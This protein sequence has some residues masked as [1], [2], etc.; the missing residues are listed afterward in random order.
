M[1][2]RKQLVPGAGRHH[3]D[4][5]N[6]HD[7]QAGANRQPVRV[8][9]A[10]GVQDAEIGRDVDIVSVRIEG[11]TRDRLVAETL[12]QI[13]PRRLAG[14]RVKPH[15]EDV[16]RRR[17]RGHR[18]GVVAG[19]RDERVVW[20]LRVKRDAA[21]EARRRVRRVDARVGDG[22]RIAR[23]SIGADEDATA[24]C[25]GPQRA[26][27]ARR[28]SDRHDIVPS[29]ISRAARALICAEE[30]AGQV[31]SVIQV[32]HWEGITGVDIAAAQRNPVAAL[33]GKVAGELVAV[34]V[35]VGL[36]A[37]IIRRAEDVLLALKDRVGLRHVWIV[38]DRH[39]EGRAFIV[40]ERIGDPI[41]LVRRAILEVDVVR[42]A[43]E[44]VERDIARGRR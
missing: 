23:V 12:A 5:V 34:L 44:G 21:Y 1:R 17:S 29:G 13:L 14:L 33:R 39:I 3:R 24:A 11:D 4:A 25:G 8:A 6:L 41:P 31:A 37:A 9:A 19:E 20:I 7:R 43:E 38:D 27:I 36:R 18:V 28:A 26:G 35:E 2:R 10:D 42:R 22:R 30:R 32:G 40:A 16:A 15:I